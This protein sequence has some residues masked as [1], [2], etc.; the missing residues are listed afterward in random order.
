MAAE[1]TQRF[2]GRAMASPLALLAVLEPGDRGR[3]PGAW[4]A[5]LDEF[6][7]DALSRFR[8]DSEVSALNRASL[9]GEGLR[10]QRRLAIAAHACD[11]AH[12]ITGGRFDPR[13]IGPLDAWGYAGADLG[14]VVGSAAMGAPERILERL[15]RRSIRIA[16][17]I[18]LGGIGKGLAI[19]W[20]ATRL[21][22]AGVNRFLLDA[23]GDIA[24]GGPGPETEP[25]RIGI[26]DPTGGSDPIAVVALQDGS[27][28][29]S[30]VR[31]RRWVADGRVR[32][33]LVDPATGQPADRGLLAV[34]VA[35]P[36][37]AW[38]E[39]WSKA[40]FIG[41]RARIAEEA[42]SRGLAAWWVTAD[43]SL[44]M[45]PAARQRTSWVLGEG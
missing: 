2:E 42:R 45:T 6:S 30:S 37:P 24:V 8:G 25:W 40:L 29:T 14:A 21:R 31:R 27:I 11:R 35:G 18:D 44:G 28:A 5:V 9:R 34:T 10:V 33:H 13:V 3:A 15:D 7:E 17:P 23:G 32:H 16:H 1:A 20:A 4:S 39:V 43:G 19:R 38:A 36:D 22:L 41:G 12:R 26:E